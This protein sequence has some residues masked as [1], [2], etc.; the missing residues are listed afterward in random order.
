MAAAVQTW[1]NSYTSSTTATVYVPWTVTSSGATA[2]PAL[3]PKPQAPLE[4][5]DSEIE[6]TCAVARG[7]P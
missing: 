6:K 5:L 3:P 4:W 1:T 2:Q 7:A